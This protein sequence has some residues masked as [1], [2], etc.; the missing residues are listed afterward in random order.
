MSIYKSLYLKYHK[1]FKVSQDTFL[2]YPCYQTFKN[3]L[4]YKTQHAVVI[5]RQAEYRLQ[6]ICIL[7]SFEPQ[8]DTIVSGSTGVDAVDATLLKIGSVVGFGVELQNDFG[9]LKRI[10]LVES[11][12]GNATLQHQNRGIWQVQAGTDFKF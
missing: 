11:N 10:A 3:L 6:I 5:F 8:D 12:F 2:Q 1:Q 9:F 4:H 7:C